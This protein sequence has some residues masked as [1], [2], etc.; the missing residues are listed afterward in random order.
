MISI[1]I[2]TLEEDRIIGNTLSYLTAHL[3]VP[4]EIIVS[5]G[6]S[7]DR[8]VEIARPLC[9]KLVVSEGQHSPARQRN[10]GAR[11]AKGDLLV[12]F[13]ADSFVPDIDAFIKCMGGRFDDASLLALAAPQRVDPARRTFFD[14]IIF[15]IDNLIVRFMNNVLHHGAGSGKCIVVRADAFRD[16]GGFDER[17]VFREDADLIARISKI[18]KTRYAP[19]IKVYHSGRRIHALGPIRFLA[20]WMSNGTSAILG[21]KAL[22]EEW[23]PIR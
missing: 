20:S 17:F 1:I 18:G 2:P 9:D 19:E 13:D 23:R 16:V 11:V 21:N 10:N 7:R 4:H 8:T 3:K 15:E 14:I 12:F 22:V 5:D 6:G